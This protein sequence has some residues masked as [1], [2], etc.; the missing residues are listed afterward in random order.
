MSDDPRVIP[1]RRG[2]RWVPVLAGLVGAVA[3]V[4][5][6]VWPLVALGLGRVVPIVITPLMVQRL[7]EGEGLHHTWIAPN[8]LP[9]SLRRAVIASEDARFCSH[10]GFDWVEIRR[11]W[12][13]YQRGERLRGASTLSMQTARTVLLWGGRDPL[14][15]GLEAWYT[16]LLEALWPKDRILDA[17]LNTVEWGPGVYGAEAAAQHF[18][19]VS[20]SALNAVQVA[21]LVAILPNPRVW[22]AS[23]PSPWIL[24]RTTT[25]RGRAEAVSVSGGQACP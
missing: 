17:Y 10:H 13:E 23:Q 24:R 8:R 21:R 4:V 25:I 3:L 12:A 19:G 11:A 16:V 1:E 15:K 20:A 14:R 6:V 22:S 2:R 7:V 18:F 5:L 9:D